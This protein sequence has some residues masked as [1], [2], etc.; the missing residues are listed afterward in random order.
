MFLFQG[1][2]EELRRL[3]DKFMVKVL[4]FIHT[5]GCKELVPIAELNGIISFCKL[6]D[7]LAT[8]DNGVSFHAMFRITKVWKTSSFHMFINLYGYCKL[9]SEM[10]VQ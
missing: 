6:F 7:I 8:P 10:I 3:F 2:V 5:S 4:T 9:L 1:M